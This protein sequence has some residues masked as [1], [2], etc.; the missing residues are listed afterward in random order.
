M[1]CQHIENREIHLKGLWKVEISRR[2]SLK[3]RDLRQQ[4]RRGKRAGEQRIPRKLK[5]DHRI[6]LPSLP[7]LQK[8]KADKIQDHEHAD[9]DG[10]IIIGQDRK[11][12]H[13]TVK[14]SFFLMNQPLQAQHD[15]RE[16]ENAVQ[17][18]DIPAIGR[19]VA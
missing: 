9:H 12:Q 3:R 10:Y 2:G 6:I 18:H 4:H 17:P 15:E 14:I 7:P 19:H 13:D 11:P 1:P 5:R 16:Q 8:Q